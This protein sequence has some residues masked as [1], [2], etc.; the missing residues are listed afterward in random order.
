MEKEA[1]LY[2]LDASHVFI[3]KSFQNAFIHRL[4]CFEK[5]LNAPT[6]LELISV[7]HVP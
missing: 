4:E 2:M 6:A 1:L 7:C 5:E 3:V